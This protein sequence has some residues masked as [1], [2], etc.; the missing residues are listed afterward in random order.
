VTE[1]IT[2]ILNFFG[3]FRLL[4]IILP[5]ERA[6]R[7]R[8]GWRVVVWEPGWHIKLPF[9]DEIVPVNNRLRMADTGCQ[10]LTTADGKTLTVG[11]T[12]GFRIPD[13]LSALLKMQ[14]PE[15]SCSVIAGSVVAALVSSSK[16]SD[17]CVDA[18]ESHV[19]AK[20]RSET[21]YEL[22]FARV[23]DFAYAR[24]IR[25]LHDNGYQRAAVIEERKL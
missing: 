15:N 6:A 9:I 2:R 12:L 7:V 13:P 25:L 3:Q 11:M 1:L 14:N 5:W 17:L 10:T 8:L 19:L 21:P 18:L 22:E 20:V 16:S 4:V 24:V 23:H